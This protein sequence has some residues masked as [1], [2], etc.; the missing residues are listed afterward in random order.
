M[1]RE[2]EMRDVGD[3][4]NI[5]MTLDDSA[6]EGNMFSSDEQLV[7]LPVLAKSYW[8]IFFF[9]FLCL[10]M[11]WEQGRLRCRCGDSNSLGNNSFFYWSLRPLSSPKISGRIVSFQR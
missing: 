10:L 4:V 3:D 8:F 7:T 6:L 1:H 2:K 5:D 9:F 11:D